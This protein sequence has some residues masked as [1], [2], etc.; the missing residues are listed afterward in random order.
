MSQLRYKACVP[1][2]PIIV[3]PTQSNDGNKDYSKVALYKEATHPMEISSH[4]KSCMWQK[5]G[6]IR[7]PKN[8]FIPTTEDNKIFSKISMLA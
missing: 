1:F 2:A 6:H 3:I 5:K 7:Y 8:S 4:A